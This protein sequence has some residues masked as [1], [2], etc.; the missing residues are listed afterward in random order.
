M[1]SILIA[2][3]LA[4]LSLTT[5][6][7]SEGDLTLPDAR[8]A[9]KFTAYVCDQA[10]NVKAENAPTAFAEKNI[11][12]GLLYTDYSLDNV[13]MKA[14][15]TENGVVCN[16]SA[17]LLADNAAWTVALVDSRAYAP[18]GGSD[19][20]EGKAVLDAALKFNKYAYLHGRVAIFSAIAGS[21]VSCGAGATQVGL[22]FQAT[23][24]L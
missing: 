20:T 19:C 14:S 22:H 6:F 2:S 12:L 10:G 18:A 9:G 13:L 16:Y 3:T 11:V 7:A 23:G 17:L 8:W 5:A 24:K 15:F 4:V 1:K 21:E